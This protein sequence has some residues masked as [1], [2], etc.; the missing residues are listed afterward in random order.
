MLKKND[1][2]EII[3]EE[4]AFPNKGIAYINGE[5]VIIKNAIKGQ[6]V[7]ARITKKRRDKIEASII[8]IIERSPV[9]KKALCPHFGICGGCSYQ[10]LPYD[11]QLKIKQN[12][13]KHLL[14]NA[15]IVDYEF[16]EILPSP[17]E[18]T[19]RNKMEF[20]FG[21][22]EK[23]GELALG[24]HKKG[25]YYEM[26]TVDGCKIVDDDFVKIMMEVLEYFKKRKIPFYHNRKHEGYLRHLVVRK[27]MKLGQILVNLV[28]SSQM[29][30]DLTILVEKIKQLELKGELKGFLHTINDSLAN[31]V[32]SDETEILYGQD[33]FMEE[34]LGLKFKV[35]AFSFFQTNSLG[36]E[37]L[38]SVVR[39]LAGD[40][41]DKTI[42]D[43]YCGTGTISQII[44]D[45]SK[46][47][48][49]IEIVEEAV[50]AAKENAKLNN[51]KNCEFIAGDVL[52]KV[53]E[54]KEKPDL[55]ILDP[56]RDGIHPKAINKIISFGAK[57]MIYVS[58]KPTSLMRDLKIFEDK[59]Y[60]VEKVRCVDMFPQTSHVETVVLMSRVK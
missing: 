44:A 9:E 20:S 36:A 12:Q 21:D 7:K 25:A 3:I 57:Q 39:D 52:T 27:S 35:S 54:L 13:V 37:K 14:D 33:F 34:I 46:K 18:Y 43:L 16:L 15:G 56:P 31:I 23:D 50:E 28:T 49:G 40:T 53:D 1:I 60:K 41:R 10:T 48:I 24:M 11:E 59:G 32:K 4:V 55:I 47:V 26:V 42:F 58:C 17:S 30:L 2:Y 6:K 38:Y 8:E 51:L 45:I 5:T 29:E 22:V 19:Y